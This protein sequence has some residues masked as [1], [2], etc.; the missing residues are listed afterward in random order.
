MAWA[1]KL[2]TRLIK[3]YGNPELGGR[4]KKV[5]GSNIKI[6]VVSSDGSGEQ[7]A[8]EAILKDWKA[9]KLGDVSVCGHSNGGGELDIISQIFYNKIKIAYAATI[10]RTLGYTGSKLW[11]SVQYFD[12]FWA[13]LRKTKFHSTFTGVKN[14]W[15]LDKILKQDIGHTPS[16][17]HPFVQ[18]KIFTEVTKRIK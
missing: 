7:E 6:W 8:I 3:H 2:Q 9:G 4:M 5:T 15:D 1:W 17:S 14:F 16:A 11:G 18:D 12:E 10:D 13:G